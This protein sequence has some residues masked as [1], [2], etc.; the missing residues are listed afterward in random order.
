MATGVI[1]VA[2]YNGSDNIRIRTCTRTNNASGQQGRGQLES[3]CTG[4]G[5][6]H[7]SS[8]NKLN[9]GTHHSK[10]NNNW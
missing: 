6:S 2:D 8:N 9:H 7:S 3:S 1:Q 10:Q 5:D 4:D